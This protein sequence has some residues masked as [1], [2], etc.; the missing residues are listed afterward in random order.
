MIGCVD[1]TDPME[2]TRTEIYIARDLDRLVLSTTVLMRLS[3]A[4]N[5][6]WRYVQ[7]V[8]YTESGLKVRFLE[9]D[10]VRLLRYVE[11]VEVGF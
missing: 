9:E 10:E 6:P 8:S 3:N 11:P 1:S 2:P 4:D 7:S 5:A